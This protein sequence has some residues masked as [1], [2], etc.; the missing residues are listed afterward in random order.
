MI[1]KAFFIFCT[2]MLLSFSSNA[3]AIF[4]SKTASVAFFS[5]TVIENIE[6][7]SNVA[8]AVIDT[9]S[10]NVLFKVANTSFQFKKKLMQEHFNENYMES[11][12]YPYSTFKGKIK[13]EVDLSKNGK[14][15]VTLEGTLD[16]HGVSKTY[17]VPAVFIVADGTINAS[18]VFKI[19]ISDHH[20][21]VPTLVFKNIAEFMEVRASASYQPKK[22]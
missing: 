19:K 2:A 8:N 9:K 13:E 14:Y 12:K 15:A 16:L 20:I 21:D 7:K 22:S 6:G 3:Q 11:D 10:R 4:I 5:S 18:T 1:H 17:L